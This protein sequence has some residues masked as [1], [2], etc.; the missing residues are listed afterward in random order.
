MQEA[1]SANEQQDAPSK[2]TCW[3]KIKIVSW[4]TIQHNAQVMFHRQ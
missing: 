3:M 1:K 2:K 4:R